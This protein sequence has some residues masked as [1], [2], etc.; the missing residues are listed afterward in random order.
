MALHR[1]AVLRCR[2]WRAAGALRVVRRG[3]ALPNGCRTAGRHPAADRG[4]L[5]NGAAP[6]RRSAA[7]RG[8]CRTVVRCPAPCCGAEWCQ[9]AE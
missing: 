3:A 6:P 1:Q 9:T 7:D 5:P 4:T 8:A 2:T